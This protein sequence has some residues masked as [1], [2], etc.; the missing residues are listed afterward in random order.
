MVL[1][2][3]FYRLTICEKTLPYFCT[4]KAFEV[5][6]SQVFGNSERVCK[7]VGLCNDE[8]VGDNRLV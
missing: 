5:Y 4:T 3:E 2:Q 6:T 8:G 1:F 7:Q